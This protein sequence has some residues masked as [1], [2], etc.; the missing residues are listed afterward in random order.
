LALLGPAGAIVQRLRQQIFVAQRLAF[1]QFRR[2]GHGRQKVVLA[3]TFAFFDAQRLI[4]SIH[5][6]VL[7]I[8]FRHVRYNMFVQARIVALNPIR[9]RLLLLQ[10]IRLPSVCEI[11]CLA[12]GQYMF[13]AF[14]A[15]TNALLRVV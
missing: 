4:G 15:D 12:L 14:G 2:N 5:M 10:E 8:L 7:A 6:N 1:V 3:L 9:I 13:P 11:S